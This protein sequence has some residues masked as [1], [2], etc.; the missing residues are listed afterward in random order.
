MT[1]LHRVL[2]RALVVGVACLQSGDSP[3]DAWCIGQVAQL[4]RG[5]RVAYHAASGEF[6][7][8]DEVGRLRRDV[9]VRYGDSCGYIFGSLCLASGAVNSHSTEGV[10][11]AV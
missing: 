9:V 7:G 6:L 1:W 8:V 4:R 3:Q 11:E 5:L 2:R 10:H